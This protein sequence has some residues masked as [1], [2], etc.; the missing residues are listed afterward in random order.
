MSP[1]QAASSISLDRWAAWGEPERL[2]VN[3]ANIYHELSE[4]PQPLNPLVCFE[5]MAELAGSR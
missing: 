2:A 5:A 1:S 3:I 4:D